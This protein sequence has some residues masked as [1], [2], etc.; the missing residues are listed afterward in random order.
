[1]LP[2]ARYFGVSLSPG[3]KGLY[4]S[5]FHTAGGHGGVAAHFRHT[6]EK[7]R[8]GVRRRI[9]RGEAGRAGSDRSRGDGQSNVI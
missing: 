3:G 2:A 5:R 8:E 1:M 6:I 7:G 4:Y 9:S